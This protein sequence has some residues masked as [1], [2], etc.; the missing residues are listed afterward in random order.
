MAYDE[1]DV[2][3]NGVANDHIRA[4]YGEA[5]KAAG[6]VPIYLDPSTDAKIATQLC[7]GVIISGGLDVPPDFYG[8]ARENEFPLSARRRVNWERELIRSCD[9]WSVPI[10]GICYGMQLLNVHY[11]GTLYQDVHHDFKTSIIHSSKGT[12]D[13]HVVTFSGDMLGFKEGDSTPS[14]SRHHQAV[15]ELAAGFSALARTEDG[16]VEAMAGNGHFGVQ[17]HPESDET[18]K[19]VYGPFLKYCKRPRKVS[20]DRLLRYVIRRRTTA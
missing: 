19:Y 15:K 10:L 17:W 6:G 5:V 8:E 1:R 12:R 13:Q 4:E 2:L 3:D 7:D 16:V 18:A 9:E 20:S 14:A 11:G